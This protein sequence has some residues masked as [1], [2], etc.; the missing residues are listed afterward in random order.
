MIYG[1]GEFRCDGYNADISLSKEGSRQ[2]C[3]EAG[4]ITRTKQILTKV[5][6]QSPTYS[7]TR[8]K[9]EFESVFF[10]S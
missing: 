4:R 2:L 9:D 3:F 7:P 8:K 5:D 1:E 10:E 6:V